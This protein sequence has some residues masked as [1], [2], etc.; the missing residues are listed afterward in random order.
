MIKLKK[1]NISAPYVLF[2]TW[3]CFPVSITQI[4]KKSLNVIAMLKKTPKMYLLYNEEMKPITEIYKQ[5]KK[6]RVKSKYLL[7]VKITV[8]KDQ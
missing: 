4:K 5:N 6:R 8:V 1:A 3:F 2:D 7:S